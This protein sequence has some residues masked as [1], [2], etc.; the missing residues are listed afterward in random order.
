[1]AGWIE[2]FLTRNFV[3][4]NVG[5]QPPGPTSDF[6]YDEMIGVN[7]RVPLTMAMKVRAVF[8]CIRVLSESTGILPLLTY[9]RTESGKE[10]AKDHWLYDL[11]HEKPND[12]QTPLDFWSL[13]V[14]HLNTRGY[15]VAFKVPGENLGETSQLLPLNPDRITIKQ[16][17]RGLAMPAL[18]YQYRTTG[19]IRLDFVQSELFIV[20]FMSV[21]GDGTK[22]LSVLEAASASISLA[23]SAQT[24]GQKYYDNDASSSVAVINKHPFKTAGDRDTDREEF[25]KSQTGANK[26]KTMYIQG[27]ADVKQLK[28][29]HKDAQF[30]ESRSFQVEEI[31]GMFRV[32]PH[33]IG[34]LARSTNNNIEE[35]G[36]QFTRLDL[37]PF[38][39]RIEQSVGRDLVTEE[40]M[41]AQFLVAALERGDI[42]T[43]YDAY[44]IAIASGWIERNEVREIEGFNRKPEIDGFLVPL[45]MVTVSESNSQENN[46]RSNQIAARQVKRIV[47]VEIV[48]VAKLAKKY[49]EDEPAFAAAVTAFYEKQAN[50]IH[51]ALCLPKATA[52]PYAAHNLD[53]VLS[54]GI[55]ALEN[56]AD[57]IERR[58]LSAIEENENAGT[59]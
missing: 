3:S 11:L 50:E 37:M 7:G 56:R 31:A 29:G 43:R 12:R 54:G 46:S 28:I 26:Y 25:Q 18:I 15:F 49:A 47:S 6:W 58:L 40:D 53:L 5:S 41:F 10:R 45:N 38:L 30:L 19:G 2:Q 22:P 4:A 34:H 44:R 39:V 27:D 48:A 9:R 20:N 23:L 17:S 21:D 55:K 59:E 13:V 8:A 24:H 33:M 52:E 57:A 16:V 1:M 32:P 42:K 36:I 35:Q 51:I 14:S